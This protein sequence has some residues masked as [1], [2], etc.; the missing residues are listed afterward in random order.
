MRRAQTLTT[1]MLA[2]ALTACGTAGGFA[3]GPAAS[4]SGSASGSALSSQNQQEGPL[5]AQ[6]ERAFSN[7]NASTSSSAAATST[8]SQPQVPS[9]D[10][11]VLNPRDLAAGTEVSLTDIERAGGEDAFFWVEPIPDDVFARMQG[12]SFGEDCIVPRDDLR[13]LKVL[14][15]NA[16]DVVMV[17]EMVVHR[18]VA[19]EV[20]DIFHKLYDA[21]WPIKKMHLVDDYDG[22]DDASCA[23]GNSSSFNF[24]KAVNANVLSNHAY[25]LAID[26]N[27]FENPYYIPERDYV[28]PPEAATYLNRNMYE[29]YMIHRD[30]LCYELFTEH[31][32][33]WGGD[34][35]TP[36]D[37][38]HFEKPSAL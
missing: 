11:V 14:H 38:Q 25:G 22:S 13:Y 12:K 30:D 28:Y 10:A 9:K 35:P 5:Y 37:Y 29:P 7:P 17:G 32:W 1:A 33:V 27:T 23:D 19:D 36:V 31:G 26:I 4:T 34:W 16:E 20:L 24:R 21:K 3:P 6:D 2:L 15:V 8:T 18:N